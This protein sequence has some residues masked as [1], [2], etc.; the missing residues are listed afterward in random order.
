MSKP[1]T[2][3]PTWSKA[4]QIEY[5]M[6][7]C[8]E[9]ERALSEA[10]AERD[11]VWAELR[12]IR[13]AIGASPEESTLDEVVRFRAYIAELEYSLTAATNG[14]WQPQPNIE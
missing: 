1:Y 5:Y 8:D 3:T 4:K 7:R 2:R 12:A 6:N 10:Q 11:T 9:L 14:E 13:E